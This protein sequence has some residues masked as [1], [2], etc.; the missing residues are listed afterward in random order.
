[1]AGQVNNRIIEKNWILKGHANEMEIESLSSALSIDKPLANLLIQRGLKT[2]EQ[3]KSFFHPDIS[4][5]HD[6]FLMKDMDV[7]VNRIEAAIRNGESIM[8]YGDYDVDGTTSV[9]LIYTFFRQ[10]YK[11]LDFYIPDR[12][13][14]GYG[15]SYKG[16][17]YA[18]EQGYSLIIALDC[19][20]KATEKVQYASRK[21]IDFI[22]CDHHNPGDS[23]PQ[24]VAVLDPKRPDCNYPYNELSGCGVGF[25]L[26]QA[27]S[28]KNNIPFD[29]L[30]KYLD[31]VAVSIASDIVPVTG[32]NRVLAYYGLKQLNENPGNGLKAIIE[33]SGIADKEINVEDV[34]FKI[35]PRINAAGRIESGKSSVNLLISD[36]KEEAKIIGEKVEVY[37]ETR[38]NIDNTITQEALAIVDQ[39]SKLVKGKTTVLFNPKWHKG[40]IGIVASRIIDTHYKPTVILTESNGFATGSARSVSGFDLYQAIESCSDLLENFGG[41]KYAAGLTMKLENIGKF[42]KRFEKYVEDTITPEQLI[43]VVEIDTEIDLNDISPNFFKIL[44]QFEPFGPENMTPIFLT[45][46]V[47]DNGTGK[48]VGVKGD[49]LKLN[50]IQE[51]DPYKVYPAIAFQQ[52]ARYQGIRNGNAFDI[53]FSIEENEFMGR[54]TL[55]LNIKDIKFD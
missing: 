36:N 48:T 43:P 24:A 51:S 37:N 27:Y 4:E 42:Q 39:D 17:D 3:A 38:R 35:G 7:A 22:I 26:I 34:V 19:G 49:H 13:D 21:G 16:I 32:E 54:K 1:M 6:P 8:I 5:L 33:L 53:C 12:Y 9:A 10:F 30:K 29:E 15:I 25:K 40:V 31:L 14:E 44:K 45:E 2:H 52:G 11:Y 41:H 18:F 47:V 50:L 28:A 55:Q 23:I 20:I 46:N